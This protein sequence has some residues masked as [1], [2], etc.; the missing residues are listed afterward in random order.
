YH[1]G[2]LQFCIGTHYLPFT[3]D[4]C[5]C[6]FFLNTPS[7]ININKKTESP[8]LYYEL[9]VAGLIQKK[10][11]II[12]P[13]LEHGLAFKRNIEFTPNLKELIKITVHDLK[14]WEKQCSDPNNKDPFTVLYHMCM[15]HEI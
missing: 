15:N 10:R 13:V 3:I 8:W 1:T 2:L 4:K 14:N 11:D 9:N 12:E 7:S 6:M 5:E